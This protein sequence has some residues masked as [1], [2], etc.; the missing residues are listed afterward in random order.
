MVTQSL[1]SAD[2]FGRIWQAY[3]YFYTADPFF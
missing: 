3:F 1:N 2:I